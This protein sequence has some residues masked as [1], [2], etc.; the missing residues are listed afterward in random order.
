MV[1]GKVLTGL[2]VVMVV[3]GAQLLGTGQ[4]GG[5][6]LTSEDYDEIHHLY[7]R[8][9][10]TIDTGDAEGLADTFTADGVFADAHG[11][12]ALVELVSTVYKRNEELG[13][14]S[15][16]WNNQILIEPT[17]DGARGTCYLVLYNTGVTPPVIRLAGV[18]K[19]V[20]VKT[21]NGWRFKER[22]V[23]R[24]GPAN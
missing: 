18:S 6:T 2:A 9:A 24:D 5:G 4:R 23:E 10:H 22:V 19:D 7:A 21:P 13:R 3:S 1:N 20:L 11:R 15:R 8:F 17:A 12:A 16:H 14:Q